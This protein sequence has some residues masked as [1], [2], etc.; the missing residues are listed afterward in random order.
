M[1][2]RTRKALALFLVMAA[3]ALLNARQ[4]QAVALSSSKGQGG[5]VLENVGASIRF[6][7][8]ITFFATI[9]AS[10]PIRQ[11]SIIITDE[12]QGITHV[13][14][15]MIDS[16]GRA[17]FIFDAR[18]NALRPFTFMRWRYEFVLG[19]GST[20]QS[21]SFF[22]RYD[23]NRFAW[24]S[25][26][27]GV[28][29][30][31]WV[32]RDPAFGQNALTIAQTGLQGM[33]NLIPVDLSQPVDIFIY[34]SQNDLL[35]LGGETWT[36]GHADPA[37]G[38]VL[39]AVEP[40]DHQSLAMEQ[41]IPHELMHVMLYRQLGTGYN[42]LPAWL[43]EG[44]ATL[45]EIN[46]SADYDR[47]LQDAGA[48]NAL[49]PVMDLCASFPSESVSAFLAYAEARSFTA[50]LR[51]MYGS[52][53]LLELARHYAD[54]VDC[55]RGVE[56][57]YG[58]SL[59]QLEF[60]WHQTA[61]GQNAWGVALRNMLPYLILCGLVLFIPLLIGFNSMRKKTNK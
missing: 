40:D 54:G 36:A 38:V 34:P 48:R 12:G 20:T 9:K 3:S 57:V 22:I 32:Q 41:R 50:Y 14:Q 55:A 6:G 26:G 37:L 42:R 61:L 51:D 13:G 15:I 43:R 56:L 19:D 52:S 8:Q 53:A 46:P 21:E 25:L 24:Q 5:I 28:L 17:E 45:A 4:A 39:V 59:V 11:A 16:Q 58:T 1:N 7:E 44:F 60:M 49:I 47:V 33:E 30:V 23:D 31:S 18:Q 29:R 35:V 2:L 27:S 10:I